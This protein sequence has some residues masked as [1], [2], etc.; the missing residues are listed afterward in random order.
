MSAH[1]LKQKFFDE[2]EIPELGTNLDDDELAEVLEGAGFIAADD[3]PADAKRPLT[4]PADV[5]LGCGCST[6]N[7]CPGG[8]I[9]ATPNLCSNCARAER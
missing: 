3:I 4:D 5:C 9:W 1:S 7:P 2:D 6:L 8:C